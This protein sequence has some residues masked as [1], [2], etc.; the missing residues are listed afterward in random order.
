[1]PPL[2]AL[3]FDLPFGLEPKLH[4][5]ID[6]ATGLLP[7]F[8]RARSY[9]AA[10]HH[11]KQLLLQLL[12]EVLESLDGGFVF[13]KGCRSRCEFDL[14][15]YLLPLVHRKPRRSHGPASQP[16]LLTTSIPAGRLCSA[17]NARSC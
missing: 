15:L 2:I 10:P 5:P 11:A 12:G 1:V 7:E 13:D 4:V 3:F 8:V 9:L 14:V 17:F 6:R 16:V